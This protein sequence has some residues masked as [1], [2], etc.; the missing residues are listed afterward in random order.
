MVSLEKNEKRIF[1]LHMIYSLIEGIIL[2]V[3]VL[4]EFI[5]VKS[6][7]GSNEQLAFLFQATS[8]LLFFSVVLNE[9]QRR[10]KRKRL[11]LAIGFVTRLPLACL[12]F[13]PTN[14]AE[15]AGDNFWHILFLAIFL[16]YYSSSP[17]ILPVINNY[18]KNN[19]RHA[20]FGKLYSY[21]TSANK[22]V[23]LAATFL[24]G[25]LL[26]FDNYA[27]VYIYPIMAALGFLSI[28]LLAVMDDGKAEIIR[29]KS[30]TISIKESLAEMKGII[31]KNKPYRD[32][33][34]GFMLYGF[35]FMIA[36]S[37]TT[38]FMVKALGLNYSSI[39]FYKNFYNIIT[40]I[41]LPYFGRLIDKIDPRKFAMITFAALLLY[42]F[43]MGLTEFFPYYA[44]FWDFK[45]Y[46]ALIIA[47]IF[48]GLFE[49]MMALLWYIGSAYFGKN[50]E[51]GV[52]QSI[53]LTMVGARAIIAPIIGIWLFEMFGFSAVFAVAVIL[54]AWSVISMK[55][56][57]KRNAAKFMS[58]AD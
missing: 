32:F 19:Y 17:L 15:L 33:E 29:R 54:L 52:Y 45:I 9:V 7:N 2:G 16:L 51:A 14:P 21:A 35:A 44:T 37:V 49:S 28:C 48:N 46:Y 38:I 34:S 20:H 4:N 31:K 13:F 26:D 57:M 11:L 18:L 5:F 23:M 58:T 40:I 10:F 43:F 50:E 41:F 1:S 3:F 12:A 39:A 22:I 25:L 42:Y 47:F 8:I 36:V 6:L 55:R 53:H 30:F 24:F 27:F 56:S